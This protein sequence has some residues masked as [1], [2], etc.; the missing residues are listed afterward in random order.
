MEALEKANA[1]EHPALE[2]QCCAR[3]KKRQRTREEWKEIKKQLKKAR[4]DARKKAREAARMT[5]TPEEKAA[6]KATVLARIEEKKRAAE[7]RDTQPESPFCV[8]IDWF[9]VMM[10]CMP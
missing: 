4:A 8:C 1:D 9:V 5:E 3:K 6:H 7:R 10:T 2:E